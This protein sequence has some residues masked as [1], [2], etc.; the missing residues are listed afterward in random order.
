MTLKTQLLLLGLLTLALPW[1]AVDYIQRLDSTLRQ[2]RLAG[3]EELAASAAREISKESALVARLAQRAE[4]GSALFVD[5]LPQ[6]SLLDGYLS[7]W[8]SEAQSTLGLAQRF[9][10]ENGWQPF[11]GAPQRVTAAIR[12]AFSYSE[13]RSERRQAMWAGVIVS[14]VKPRFYSPQRDDFDALILRFEN[15][16]ALRLTSAASGAAIVERWHINKWERSFDSR[17]YWQAAEGDATS[18]ASVTIEWSLPLRLR[19]LKFTAQWLSAE[20]GYSLF[21]NRDNKPM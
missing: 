5:D 13:R 4:A 19:Y 18:P 21:L 2:T 10:L 9:S 20:L 7:D 16:E 8:H 11:V 15:N 17:A 6:G 3:V 1:L 14:G 12:F